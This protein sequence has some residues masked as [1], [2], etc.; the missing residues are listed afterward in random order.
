MWCSKCKTYNDGNYCSKC[1][2]LLGVNFHS[3]V[4]I[5]S[6][7]V[8]GLFGVFNYNINFKNEHNVSILITPNGCGKTTI[9]NLLDFILNPTPRTLSKIIEVPFESIECTLSSGA[10]VLLKKKGIEKYSKSKSGEIINFLY[11]VTPTV[12]VAGFVVQIPALVYKYDDRYY[13]VSKDLR[14]S[15][16]LNGLVKPIYDNL[17]DMYKDELD[18]ILIDINMRLKDCRCL[19][20]VNYSR[21]NRGFFDYDKE[22]EYDQSGAWHVNYLLD[23]N[24]NI[25][26]HKPLNGINRTKGL[27]ISQVYNEMKRKEEDPN[28]DDSLLKHKVNIFKEIY[29][30]RNMYTKKTI[31]FNE[32]GF[33][34]LQNGKPINLDFLSTGEKNDFVL[35]FDLMFRSA[36]FGVSIIDE[37]EISLHIDWQETLLDHMMTICAIN[38]TQV[39]VSTHSPSVVSGK[40][41]LLADLEVVE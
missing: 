5:D 21:A 15:V 38:N 14:A 13:L 17:V 1:G 19:P 36:E 31:E 30:K 27:I 8:R 4:F 29:D 6:V 2:K 35:L 24:D 10:T 28:Y 25:K 41:E 9:F 32:R 3:R 23:Y 12:G 37:P 26:S 18:K 34:I 39:I 33:D 16:Y 22:F 7:K 40:I 20:D 11:V